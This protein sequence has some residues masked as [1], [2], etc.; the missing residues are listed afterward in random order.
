[1]T[2]FTLEYKIEEQGFWKVFD[3]YGTIEDAIEASCEI[4]YDGFI[5]R[6]V[7]VD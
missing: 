1:M 5:V 2:T 4:L 6:I 3:H 7:E